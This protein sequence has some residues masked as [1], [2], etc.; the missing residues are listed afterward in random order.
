MISLLRSN[1]PSIVL[2]YILYLL[3]FRV[4]A[5]WISPP[6]LVVTDLSPISNSL[7]AYLQQLSSYTFWSLFLAAVLTFVQALLVNLIINENKITAKKNY[8]G[9]AMYIIFVSFFIEGIYLSPALLAATFIL[10]MLRS[11][12][13]LAR[14]EKQNG[15]IF[16]LGF[17]IA[18]ASMIYFPTIG[19]LLFLLVGLGAIRTFVAR[20]W[21]VLL[22][23][24][25]AP[26]C[27]A[28]T[29]YFYNDLPYPTVDIHNWLSD[30]KISTGQKIQLSL[31]ASLALLASV[32][33]QAALSGVAIQ[34]RKFNS[35]L[36]FTFFII[37][38]SFFLQANLSWSHAAWLAV[39]LSVLF[40]M[41]ILQM[42]RKVWVEILHSVLILIIIAFQII[43]HL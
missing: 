42:K 29:V 24:W 41:V 38:G 30:W 25:I 6:L 14:A 36:Q 21:V 28:F 1:N 23:G 13:L 10:L 4:C 8:L 34:V 26:F 35:L 27:V 9:G 3:V 2:L 5:V 18:I 19:F 12:F 37:V 7:F 40:T 39:P 33:S 16:D 43:P 11:M 15:N 32:A 22:L 17:M 31:L 20:E